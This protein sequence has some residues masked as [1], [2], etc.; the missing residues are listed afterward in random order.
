MVIDEIDVESV[1]VLVTENDSPIP[2][3]R[4]GP[5]AFEITFERVQA[6]TGNIK[7]S[8]RISGIERGKNTLNLLAQRS[9]DPARVPAF[10]KPLKATMPKAPD[11]N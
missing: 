11:H 3:D 8:R 5:E 4:H 9:A 1:A 10:V 2:T 6:K 7:L